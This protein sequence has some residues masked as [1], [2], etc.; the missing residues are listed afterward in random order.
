MSLVSHIIQ[1]LTDVPS[2]GYE[3]NG[4]NAEHFITFCVQGSASYID[5]NRYKT[6]PSKPVQQKDPHIRRKLFGCLTIDLWNCMLDR[7]LTDIFHHVGCQIFFLQ[8]QYTHESTHADT[9]VLQKMDDECGHVPQQLKD[10]T[11][12]Q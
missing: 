10:M 12:P 11:R 1:Q 7:R 2:A 6:D 8:A 5:S 3:R 4:T 9:T